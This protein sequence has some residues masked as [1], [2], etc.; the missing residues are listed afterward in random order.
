MREDELSS[1]TRTN[2]PFGANATDL[3]EAHFGKI[4]FLASV[5][6]YFLFRSIRAVDI[7][8]SIFGKSARDA[9][10]SILF[11]CQESSSASVGQISTREQL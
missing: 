8:S 9:G 10:M 7:C 11:G 5:A 3:N 1:S 4:S 6:A 2:F